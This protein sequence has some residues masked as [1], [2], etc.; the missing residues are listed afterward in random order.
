M[1]ARI[2]LFLLLAAPAFAQGGGAGQVALATPPAAGAGSGDVVGP[3]SSTNNAW[4]LWNGGTGKILKNSDVT[5]AT[6]VLSVPDAFNIS[7]AGSI[8]LTAGGASEDITLSPSGTDGEINLQFNTALPPDVTGTSRS[9][10]LIGADSTEMALVL[11]SYA[12]TP[13]IMTYRYNGSQ[14]VPSTVLNGNTILSISARG[15]NGSALTTARTA[16]LGMASE[17]WTTGANGTTLELSTTS[18][19]TTSRIA[20]MT[21]AGTAAAA[22]WTG[23]ATNL[24]ITAGT[25]NSRTMTLQ[26]TTSGGTATN[27]LTLDAAQGA[28][29]TGVMIMSTDTLSGAGAVSV[30]KDTTKLT[31]SGVAQAITLANGVDGQIKRIIHDVDGGSMVLTHATKTGWS[32]ATF[33]NAGETL[34]LEYATTRGWFVLSSYLTVVAP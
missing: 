22:T 6:P 16:I 20:R 29:F 1:S 2:L 11:Y 24:T 31:S 27:A 14:A 12:A 30:T 15:Y 34:T 13:A 32:T 21:L 25:G 8:A 3:A 18:P 9:V 33:T 19:T 17:D 26:T 10:N 4:A 7:S 5:Y 23:G 28:T